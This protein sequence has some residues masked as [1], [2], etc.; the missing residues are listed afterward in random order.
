ML[1]E[2]V[3]QELGRMGWGA[4]APAERKEHETQRASE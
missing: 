3:G 1:G 4:G 2:A